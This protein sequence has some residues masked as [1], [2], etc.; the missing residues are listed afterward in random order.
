M[1]RPNYS[2]GSRQGVRV[3]PPLFLEQT[4]ARRAEKI[5]FETAPPFLSVWMTAPPL[6][7]LLSEDLDPP[8]NYNTIPSSF[9]IRLLVGSEYRFDIY[10]ASNVSF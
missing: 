4:E 8:L 9:T 5:F 3:P 6:P 10:L 7:S 1:G 2:G